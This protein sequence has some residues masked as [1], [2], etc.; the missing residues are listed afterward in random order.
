MRNF[1]RKLSYANVTAT[2][3][4]FIAVGGASAFAATQL[5]KS[6]VGSNQIKKNAVTTAKI[7]NKAVTERKIKNAAITGEKIANA[8]VTGSKVASGSLTGANINLGTL[9]MVPSANNANMVN[10]QAPTKIFKILLPGETNV[11]VATVSGFSLNASC[12]S[13]KAAV[14]LTSPSSAGS[15]L[16]AEGGGKNLAGNQ[17]TINYAAGKAGEASSIALNKEFLAASETDFGEAAFSGAT[18]AGAVIS[19][20]I[21]YDF[22][23]FNNESPERCL[24]FGQV[25]AG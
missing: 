7:K 14:N 20:Q 10:G 1:R 12:T 19:G 22:D 13:E 4:L 23:T 17:H 8:A 15:V 6:S 16:I 21:G 24:V 2:L 5:K 25:T 11:A 3:A 9:P 18:A